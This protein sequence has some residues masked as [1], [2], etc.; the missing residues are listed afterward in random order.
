[1]LLAARLEA[2]A[3]GLE[4]IA[5][6][7]SRLEAITIRLEAIASRLEAI[8]IRL[9]AIASRLL[10]WTDPVFLKILQGFCGQSLRAVCQQHH[11]RSV[12]NI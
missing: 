4:A 2:I 9:E 8:A 7:A 12:Y 11:L 10:V 5:A 3:S 1:M 6:I